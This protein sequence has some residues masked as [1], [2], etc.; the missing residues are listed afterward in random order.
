MSFWLLALF[1]DCC[2]SQNKVNYKL[3]RTTRQWWDAVGLN[4]Q[5]SGQCG[6]WNG[7]SA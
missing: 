3:L 4:W 5:G 6:Q 2:E 1:T 7:T